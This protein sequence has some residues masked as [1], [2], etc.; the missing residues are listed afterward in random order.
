[1]EAIELIV[2]AEYLHPFT[3][4]PP[5]SPLAGFYRALLR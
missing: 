1:M 5:A 3:A 2:A 4:L